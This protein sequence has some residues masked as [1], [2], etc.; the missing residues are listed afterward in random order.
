[1]NGDFNEINKALND[2]NYN[3]KVD[4]LFVEENYIQ[5]AFIEVDLRFINSS[6]V[7]LENNAKYNRISVIYKFFIKR[8]IK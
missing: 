8:V 6:L 2:A 7:K 1:M 5:S 4:N 3:L